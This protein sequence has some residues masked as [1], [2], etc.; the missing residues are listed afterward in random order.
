MRY[1]RGCGRGEMH[2]LRRWISVRRGRVDRLRRGWR[3]RRVTGLRW[4]IHDEYGAAAHGRLKLHHLGE[5]R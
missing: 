1:R 5:S 4:Q 2:R 3:W